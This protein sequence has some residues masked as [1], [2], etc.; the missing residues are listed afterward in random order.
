M[1]SAQTSSS[2]QDYMKA[3]V[4]KEKPER[5]TQDTRTSS[6]KDKMNKPM[7][8]DKFQDSIV[9]P[10]H[11]ADASAYSV[12]KIMEAI[13]SIMLEGAHASQ[14]CPWHTQQVTRAN[15]H[16]LGFDPMERYM[17]EAEAEQSAVYHGVQEGTLSITKACTCAAVLSAAM[18]STSKISS[19]EQSL[20]AD[21]QS[22]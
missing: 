14:L 10:V 3:R 12:D 22:H 16:V 19:V 13:D 18:N 8:G 1:A 6:M 9:H 15:E 7:D 11:T 17:A 2:S 4:P 5:P 21:G 20:Q